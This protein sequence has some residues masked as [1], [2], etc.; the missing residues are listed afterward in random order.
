MTGK[1]RSIAVLVAVLALAFAATAQ[2]K[3]YKLHM[4]AYGGHQVGIA[5]TGKYKGTPFGNCTMKGT[6]VIPDTKQTWYCKGG[7][8]KLTAHSTTGA[9]NNVKGTWKIS[10][11]SG[12]FKHARGSGT[13]S[14][15]ISTTKYTY[16]GKVSY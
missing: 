14:G 15:Q 3:S 16:V 9:S 12:K 11:G 4:N 6:L 8:V 1:F 10:G 5:L 13:F 2:A 7:T